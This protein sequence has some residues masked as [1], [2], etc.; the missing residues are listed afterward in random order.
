MHAHARAPLVRHG[1][2][3]R[4][5][6]LAARPC[7]RGPLAGRAWQMTDNSHA[8]GE[9][10]EKIDALLGRLSE[11]ARRD[12]ALLFG[13]PFETTD[14]FARALGSGD[15]SAVGVDATVNLQLCRLLLKSADKFG[16]IVALCPS[17][18]AT[19]SLIAPPLVHHL[20]KNQGIARRTVEYAHRAD[21]NPGQT[22][23]HPPP[24]CF[25]KSEALRVPHIDSLP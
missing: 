13:P 21:A 17:A 22:M 20:V 9:V 14:T 8:P 10:A 6:T 12:W 4:P 23:W 16:H 5:S 15:P 3:A 19:F 1:P 7:S 11:E 25:E 24:T 18:A 2:P